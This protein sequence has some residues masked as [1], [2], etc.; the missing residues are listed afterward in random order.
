[1]CQPA[2]LEQKISED[3]IGFIHIFVSLILAFSSQ[4][5]QKILKNFNV[6]FVT[7]IMFFAIVSILFLTKDLIFIL[8]GIMLVSFMFGFPQPLTNICSNKRIISEVRA[9]S[10]FQLFLLLNR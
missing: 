5:I 3:M 2:L 9:K 4:I 8:T 6:K 10:L 1:M 7:L